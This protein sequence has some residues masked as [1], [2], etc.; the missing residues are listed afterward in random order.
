MDARAC[1]RR[2]PKRIGRSANWPGR[3]GAC[4]IRICSSGRFVRREAVLS[5][6]IEGTQATLGELL[7]AEAGAIGGPQPGGLARGGQLRGGAGVRHPPAVRVA[8]VRA[9]GAG[10]PRE[11][12]DGRARRTGG[13]REVSD[14]PELDRPARLDS[15][16]G[17]L[18]AA[19]AGG[20]GELR[21]RL[22]AIP[23]R[24]GLA[25]AGDRRA[26]ALPVRGD[27]SVSGREWPRGAAA[28]HAVSHRAQDTAGT[29]ALP[30]RLLR[31]VAPGLLRI[32][33]RREPARESGTIG[34]SIS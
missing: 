27:S 11:A 17:A 14:H 29:V 23:A 25:A 30:F 31:G 20:S 2:F 7:A 18:R 19:A 8:A 24:I 15:R 10:T 22:G 6:R 34:S 21:R 26:D 13:A 28:G 33:P 3:D 5:S 12:D 4:R 16:D 1:C 32:A 9:V